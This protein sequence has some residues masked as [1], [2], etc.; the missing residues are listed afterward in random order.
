MLPESRL[1]SFLDH[2]SGFSFH[3]LEGQK[4]FME[5]VQLTDLPGSSLSSYRDMV[6]SIQ[7]LV[8]FLKH[9]E[10][11]G[12]YIDSESP[13]YRFKMETNYLGLTRILLFPNNLEKIPTKQTGLA[14]LVKIFPGNNTQDYQ[15]IIEIK[16]L[17]TSEIVNQTLK[18]SYQTQSKVFISPS[19]D[20]SLL[21]RKIPSTQKAKASKIS[22]EDYIKKNKIMIDD[23]LS[24]D[25]TDVESIVSKFENSS[26]SYLGS[27]NVKFQCNCS[28]E[29]FILNLKTISKEELKNLYKEDAFVEIKCDYCRKKYNITRASVGL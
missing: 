4:L 24:F 5:L 25:Q 3:F 21:I 7:Q 16:N 1:Y 23:F 6:L 17:S 27:K 11:L 8:T 15:S 18:E 26:L 28:Q 22:L 19:S 10:S 2:E 12:F 13:K 14:R 29:R 20:Q 9:G